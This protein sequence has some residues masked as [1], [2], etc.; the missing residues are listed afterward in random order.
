MQS[1]VS[2]E[3]PTYRVVA[4]EEFFPFKDNSLDMVVSS[5]RWEDIK[6]LKHF[7]DQGTAFLEYMHGV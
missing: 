6:Y 5:L 7:F 4:D 3:V 1:E 2:P